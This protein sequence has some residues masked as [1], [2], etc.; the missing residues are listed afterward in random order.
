PSAPLP[1]PN[2][3]AQT[4]PASGSTAADAPG[5]ASPAGPAL[6]AH[7][8][9]PEAVL[10]LLELLGGEL[11]RVFLVGCEPAAL[12]HRIGLSPPVARAVRPAADAAVALA[13]SFVLARSSVREE[14]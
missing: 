5:L 3:P 2:S 10:G 6:D 1:V 14:V 12:D 9:Q 7:G 8:M 11:G 13:R 4:F